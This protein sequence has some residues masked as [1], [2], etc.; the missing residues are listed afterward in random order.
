MITLA[1]TFYLEKLSH[2]KTDF[3][4]MLFPCI[5]YKYL[6]RIHVDQAMFP[7]FLFA[8]VYFGELVLRLSFLCAFLFFV[9]SQ[10]NFLLSYWFCKLKRENIDRYNKSPHSRT[11]YDVRTD[12]KA[13]VLISRHIKVFTY[14]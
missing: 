13:Y 6:H 11:T 8:G 2:E 9:H 1:V 7:L 10:N 12:G 3:E 5:S 14:P 4:T